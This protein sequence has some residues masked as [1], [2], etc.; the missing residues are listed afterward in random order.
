MGP[1]PA[2][3]YADGKTRCASGLSAYLVIAPEHFEVAYEATLLTA[4][5]KFTVLS[6]I[7]FRRAP[8]H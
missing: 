4:C 7:P 3:V 2:C 6:G 8:S 1:K 5:S